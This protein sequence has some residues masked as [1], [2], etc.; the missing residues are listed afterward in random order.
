V[1]TRKSTRKANTGFQDGNLKLIA[2]RLQFDLLWFIISTM[3]ARLAWLLI[4]V[5][6]LLASGLPQ[7]LH[8]RMHDWEDAC[9]EATT[10]SKHAGNTTFGNPHSVPLPPSTPRRHSHDDCPVCAA[11]HS[12]L[13]AGTVPSQPC[14]AVAGATFVQPPRL[15]WRKDVIPPSISCRGPPPSVV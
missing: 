7:S 6:A 13:F 12:P 15:I 1:R 11:F 2:S 5:F 4:L 8:Q 14:G 3:R 9:Q 10:I